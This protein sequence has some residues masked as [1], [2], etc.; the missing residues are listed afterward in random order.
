MHFINLHTSVLD[1]EHFLTATPAQRGTWLCLYRYCAG[2]E[3]GGRIPACKAWTDRVWLQI[4]GVSVREVATS[5]GL[6]MWEGDALVVAYYNTQHEAKA[7]RARSQAA[8]AAHARWHR[9][10]IPDSMP[11]SMPSGIPTVMPDGIRAGNAK[12]NIKKGKVK[13]GKV[14]KDIPGDATGHGQVP[15]SKPNGHRTPKPGSILPSEKPPEIEQRMLAVAALMGRRPST[16]WMANEFAAFTAARLDTC[17]DDD[18]AAQ[19]GDLRG[20]Y[21][22]K[23]PRETDFRRRELLT[24]LNHWSGELDK[25]RVYN[26]DNSDGYTKASA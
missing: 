3:N 2:Q 17:S 6:W 7:Q 10:G 15:I 11:T 22:A 24:L 21:G 5:C 14:M 18:F 4:C 26:R 16:P 12:D 20:Y 13:K 1:G 9:S 8:D 19:V 25:A 23:I